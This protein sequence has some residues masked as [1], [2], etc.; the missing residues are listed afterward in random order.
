MKLAGFLP[1]NQ[2]KA[3][4]LLPCLVPLGTLPGKTDRQLC[5]IPVVAVV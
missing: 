5:T 4:V 3:A 2:K 1:T